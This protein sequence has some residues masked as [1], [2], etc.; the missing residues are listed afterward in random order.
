MMPHARP[1][2]IAIK[3]IAIGAIL[4]G[5]LIGF[6]SNAH[7]YTVPQELGASVP[8]ATLSGSGR[9]RAYGFQIYDA[10]LWTAP[11]FR[12]DDFARHAFALELSYLRDFTGQNIA[13]RSVDE[14]RRIGSFTDEQAETWLRAMQVAFPDVKKGDRITGV[15]QP[16]VG[17]Q[18]LTNGKPTGEV[19]DPQFA[20]LFFGIWLSPNTSQPQLRQALLSRAAN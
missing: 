3:Y 16:G 5:A 17:A 11:G 7:A 1:M 13:K 15:H 20:R 18:F 2:P 10:A 6:G 14:M 19:R 12:A 8:S 4:T 9:M